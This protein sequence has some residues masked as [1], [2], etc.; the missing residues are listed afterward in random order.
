MFKSLLANVLAASTVLFPIA[1]AS[2]SASQPTDPLAKW[3][4]RVNKQID[5]RAQAPVGDATGVAQIAFRRGPDGRA[6]DVVARGGQPE[7]ANAGVRTIKRLRDLPPLPTGL[8]A[9]QQIVMNFLVG[10]PDTPV[11][12]QIQREQLLAL[13]ATNN[14][15]LASL[16]NGVPVA[17]LDHR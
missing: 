16:A 3:V 9:D 5:L 4:A 12:F 13:A 14:T 8:P 15:R 7:V 10:G 2:A 11:P 1:S 6:V 17:M